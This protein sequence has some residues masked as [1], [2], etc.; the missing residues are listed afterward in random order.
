MDQGCVQPERSSDRN[1]PEGKPLE[2]SPDSCQHAD[3]EMTF[4]FLW[5]RQHGGSHRG[6]PVTHSIITAAGTQQAPPPTRS[7][8]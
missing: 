7:F 1:I 3:M 8:K 6:V 2:I 4:N 5:M